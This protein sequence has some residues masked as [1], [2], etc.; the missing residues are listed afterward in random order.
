M[1]SLAQE[2]S[3]SISEMSPGDS[4]SEWQTARSVS[5]T[6]VFSGMTRVRKSTQ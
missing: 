3:R 5:L 1:S 6:V 4:E 2:E